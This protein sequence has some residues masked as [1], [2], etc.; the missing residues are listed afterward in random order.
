MDYHS[1]H[2]TKN[3]IGVI[4]QL[5]TALFSPRTISF[6]IIMR[7][8]NLFFKTKSSYFCGRFPEEKEET[9]DW[10]MSSG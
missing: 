2:Y 5:I 7:K 6:G 1:I 3:A 10:T 9:C 8:D 4:L